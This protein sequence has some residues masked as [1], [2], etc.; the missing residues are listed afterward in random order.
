MY[1]EASISEILQ[2]HGRSGELMNSDDVVMRDIHDAPQ[3]SDAYGIKRAFK[4]DPRGMSLQFSTDGMNPFS[5]GTYSMWPLTLTMLNLPK[6]VRHLLSNIMLV[7]VI[8]G[9]SAGNIKLDA[10]LEVLVDELIDLSGVEMFDGFKKEMFEFKVNH[11]LDY[12]GLNKLF[13]A[14]GA[15]A[16][17]RCMWCDVTGK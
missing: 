10:Y 9:S 11:V 8:P 4:G 5:H 14:S 16:L 3:F 12:P 7:C 6:S 17:R 13:A 15:N 2:N 1:G